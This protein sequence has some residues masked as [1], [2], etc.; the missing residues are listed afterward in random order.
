MFYSKGQTS[1]ALHVR[2]Y[3]K[4]LQITVQYIT[5]EGSGASKG[6]LMPP[7]WTKLVL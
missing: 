4:K 1:K 5:Q 3:A 2:H 6:D 7:E